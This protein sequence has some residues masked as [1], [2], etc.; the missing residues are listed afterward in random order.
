MK[1]LLH[2]RNRGEDFEGNNKTVEL[3]AIPTQGQYIALPTIAD[4]YLVTMVVLVADKQSTDAAA[5]VY[6]VKE[7][8]V[9]ARDRELCRAKA[10]L[11]SAI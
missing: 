7:P 11:S 2:M 3:S 8:R 4:W 5:E 1:I 6:A 10:W 9:D